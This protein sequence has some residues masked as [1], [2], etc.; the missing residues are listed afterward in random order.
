VKFAS[1]VEYAM[2]FRRS[3]L[4]V[5]LVLSPRLGLAQDP[6]A[7][8]Q[9]LFENGRDLLRSGKVD[10]ACPKLAESQRLQPAT[11][12]LLALAI[13][14]QTQGKLATAWVE[15]SEVAARA[16]KDGQLE[17]ES[18]AR[19]QI[20]LL[21]PRLS[22]LELRVPPEVEALAGLEV[23]M[24]GIVVGKSAWNV[25]VPVDGGE[26]V[27]EVRAADHDPWHHTVSVAEEREAILAQVPPLVPSPLTA[28]VNAE[29]AEQRPAVMHQT[30][31]PHPPTPREPLSRSSPALR[32]TGIAAA[33]AGAAALVAG[34]V[35]FVRSYQRKLDS[36]EPCSSPDCKL[37][38]QAHQ[39][40]WDLGN[41]A[42]G[43][44]IVGGALL[45]GGGALYLRH[46][47]PGPQQKSNVSFSFGPQ[48][49]VLMLTRKF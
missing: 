3:W 10:A 8:A 38:R 45:L 25:P 2:S 18:H 36:Q 41:W 46:R 49:G 33:G 43:F 39:D 42:T 31:A 21:K 9:A 48:G 24:D 29:R 22:T 32:W 44:G 6:A 34:G 11:G 4:A 13:C 20:V 27:V 47:E 35:C 37:E 26:H 15:F 19:S 30:A 28:R 23:R 16:A 7:A 12:T 40:A 14:H 1:S 5:A 17:R